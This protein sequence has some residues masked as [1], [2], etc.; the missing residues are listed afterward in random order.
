MAISPF[1]DFLRLGRLNRCAILAP[2]GQTADDLI[3]R[4]FSSEREAHE[5]IPAKLEKR[6]QSSQ[7][8]GHNSS[9]FL[10]NSSE[11]GCYAGE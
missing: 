9:R 8:H 2:C 11:K 7:Y 6:L 5:G 10:E 4:G 1:V 3:S